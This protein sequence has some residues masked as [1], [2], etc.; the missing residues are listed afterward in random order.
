MGSV[1]SGTNRVFTNTRNWQYW[2]SCQLCIPIYFSFL[3]YLHHMMLVNV[4]LDMKGHKEVIF[5]RYKLQ[6]S[7]SFVMAQLKQN[8]Q[9]WQ[10][11]I[12]ESL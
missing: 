7:G 3:L 2:H 6:Q 4:K 1:V 5:Q 11:C 9:Y 10:A 8:W 12:A